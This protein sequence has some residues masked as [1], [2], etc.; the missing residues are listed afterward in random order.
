MKAPKSML[1]VCTGNVFRSVAAQ[2]CFKKYLSDNSIA[3]WDVGSAGIT[4][5]PQSIDPR[6]LETL[7]ELGVDATGHMQRKLTRELLDSYDIVVGMAENHIEFMKSEFNY[8]HAVLFNDLAQGEL[9]SIWDIEDEIRDYQTN[10]RAVEEKIERT[11]RDIHD[12]TPQVF[13]NASE[14]FYLFSDFVNGKV[15]HRNGYPFI[16]LCE[17]PHAI[18]FMSIDIPYKEDGH[19]LVI[20]KKRYVD[21]FEI[22]DEVLCDIL[23]AIKRVGNALIADHDGYN[24]LLNNGRDAGQYMMHAHFHVIPRRLGDGIRIEFW[25]HPKISREEFIKLNEKLKK[26]I[27]RENTA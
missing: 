12:K 15:T 21:L 5:T 17:T 3:G 9:T 13:E 6:A 4:A 16:T 2:Q 19:I 11:V 18:A 27:D 14:R 10:R 8:T 25:K 7:Q 22:P 23:S 24:V 1:F 26:Q 20:P